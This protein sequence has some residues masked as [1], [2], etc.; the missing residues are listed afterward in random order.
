[1]APRR[2]QDALRDPKMGPKMAPRWPQDGM[3]PRWLQDGLPETQKWGSRF[4]AVQILLNLPVTSFS[5]LCFV[6]PVFSK[7]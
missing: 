7:P 5:S 1:M 3:R 4:G 6:F 2:L